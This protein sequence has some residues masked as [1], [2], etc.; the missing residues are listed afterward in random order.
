M[1]NKYFLNVLCVLLIFVSNLQAKPEIISTKSLSNYKFEVSNMFSLNLFID[2]EN[3]I[4]V[5]VNT[6]DFLYL[7]NQL[8]STNQY[9]DYLN[10]F[11]KDGT[12]YLAFMP[13]ES[14][15]DIYTVKKDIVLEKHI[16]IGDDLTY[17]NGGETSCKVIYIPEDINNL[18]LLGYQTQL[19]RN[20]SEFLKT[21]LSGGHGKYYDKPVLSKIHNYKTLQYHQ[22][23]YEGNIDEC[24]YI[25]K[26]ISEKDF[27][28]FFGFR[29]KE[30]G[31]DKRETS[32]PSAVILQYTK[33]NLKKK[34]VSQNNAIYENRPIFPN[35][36]FGEV[37]IDNFNDDIVIVFSWINR[38][39]IV[40]GGINKEITILS[41]IYYSQS[42]NGNFSN[43]ENIGEG[44]V[45][46]VRIDSVGNVH[47]IWVNNN[48][49]LIHKLKKGN[50]WS[51]EEV[52][53]NGIDNTPSKM[54]GNYI[55]AEFD[56][57]NILNVIYPSNGNIVH[58]KIKFD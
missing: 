22:I 50:K 45:P 14:H 32:P 37:S 9:G 6:P 16:T 48:G 5:V 7:N 53:L 15:I 43:V 39:I 40:E 17:S 33:Y 21:V 41:N 52:V 3:N 2:N 51:N 13:N 10:G 30:I 1:N 47:V 44:L 24:Y 31:A 12:L 42:V 36:L 58:A 57:D 20:P 54:Y 29:M 56:K 38:N 26:V 4:F 49:S 19:P 25:K 35:Y 28:H 23:P 55:S 18:Y 8:M 27:I 46:L 11:V 34:K